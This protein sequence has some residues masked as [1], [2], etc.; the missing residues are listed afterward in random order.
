MYIYL[1]IPKLEY[2][3]NPYVCRSASDTVRVSYK[4][5]IAGAEAKMLW[6]A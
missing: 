1:Q 5:P 4:P 2:R 3:N 6:W